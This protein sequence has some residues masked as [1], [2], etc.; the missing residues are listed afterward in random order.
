M[1]DN[2]LAFVSTVLLFYALGLLASFYTPDP[3]DPEIPSPEIVLGSYVDTVSV[4]LDLST[5]S[6]LRFEDGFRPED[7]FFIKAEATVWEFGPDIVRIWES[8]E[9]LKTTTEDKVGEMILSP[10]DTSFFWRVSPNPDPDLR[11]EIELRSSLEWSPFWDIV[12]VE[13]SKIVLARDGLLQ[14]NVAPDFS[15]AILQTFHLR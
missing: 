13:D 1:K 2:V 9:I 15:Q 5:V 11:Y 7:P 12:S 14:A 6:D 4:F 10:P 8:A 3:I